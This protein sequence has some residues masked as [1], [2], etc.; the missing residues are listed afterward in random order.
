LDTHKAM[1]RH[2]S[3]QPQIE[4][5]RANSFRARTLTGHIDRAKKRQPGQV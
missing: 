1:V 3:S 4:I 2:Y 5:E